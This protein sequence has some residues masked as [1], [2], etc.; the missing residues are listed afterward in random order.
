MSLTARNL[1]AAASV[2]TVMTVLDPD[3]RVPMKDAKGQDLTITLLGRDSEVVVAKQRE[4]RNLMVGEMTKKVPYS[5]AAQDYREA[6]ILVVATTGWSGIPKGWLRP[7]TQ[8]ELDA[9]GPD[10]VAE[11][12]EE[13][14]FSAEN[15][16]ALYT[17]HGVNW[18]HEQVSEHFDDRGNVLKALKKA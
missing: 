8:E 7:I 18:L 9:L 2:G 12:D 15:A 10:G 1:A 6:E 13:A 5:A 4:Q 17:N 3:T 11:L 16:L 14:P